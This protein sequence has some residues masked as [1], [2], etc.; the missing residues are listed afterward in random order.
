MTIDL[1]SLLWGV[2]GTAALFFFGW[3]A[4]HL[5]DRLLLP[6]LLDWWATRTRAR[7]LQ[8]ASRLIA[9][10]QRDLKDYSDV[11]ILLYKTDESLRNTMFILFVIFVVCVAALLRAERVTHVLDYV[12]PLDSTVDY[13]VLTVFTV[14][15]GL[16]L[17]LLLNLAL[18]WAFIGR[19]TLNREMIES[20]QTVAFST[21][22]RV[23]RLLVAAGLTPAE[24]DTWK[25]QNAHALMK[26]I[27]DRL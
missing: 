20:P 16:S 23:D 13:S 27:V 6:R 9:R 1:L 5:L 22:G 7:A 21:L 25:V 4:K 26:L 24:R 12:N 10:F 17:I 15:I 19:P 14:K 2:A 18:L 11:R 8:R 3:I